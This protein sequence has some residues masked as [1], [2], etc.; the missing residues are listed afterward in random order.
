MITVVNVRATSVFDYYIGR[1]GLLGNPYIVGKH[2]DRAQ[3]IALWYQYALSRSCNDWNFKASLLRCE[4]KII[5]CHCA[6]L[7]CHGDTFDELIGRLTSPL[8]RGG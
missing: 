6:P 1:P 3:C 2:G 8:R 7:A 4:N 5:A